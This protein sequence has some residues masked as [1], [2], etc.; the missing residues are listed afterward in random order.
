[1]TDWESYG[2]HS[3]ARQMYVHVEA[4]TNWGSAQGRLGRLW[5][6]AMHQQIATP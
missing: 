2:R 4:G 1:M 3:L 6:N 5:D